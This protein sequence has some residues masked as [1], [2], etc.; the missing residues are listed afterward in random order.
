MYTRAVQLCYCA[1][2]GRVKGLI[3]VAL[4][5]TGRVRCGG[6]DV[7]LQEHVTHVY[8]GLKSCGESSYRF[9]LAHTA[10]HKTTFR[11]VAF[12]T[13]TRERKMTTPAALNH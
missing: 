3:L 11:V 9:V 10:D 13:Y 12:T 2:Y 1:K 4:D 6:T 7:T 8:S 5:A